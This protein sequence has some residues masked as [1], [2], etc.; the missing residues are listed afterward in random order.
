M[1]YLYSLYRNMLLLIF[2]NLFK[3]G[4]TEIIANDAGDRVTPVLV[5]C[6]GKDMVGSFTIYCLY[7]FWLALVSSLVSQCVV[8]N[9]CFVRPCDR[10]VPREVSESR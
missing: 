8:S 7:I 6:S 5:A 9:T 4:R 3:D 1:I 2:L 10:V